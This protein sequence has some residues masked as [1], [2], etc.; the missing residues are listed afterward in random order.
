MTHPDHVSFEDLCAHVQDLRTVLTGLAYAL[1]RQANLN[2]EQLQADL[3]EI[4][5]PTMQEP[6]VVADELATLLASSILRGKANRPAGA[7][8]DAGS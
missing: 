8:P 6:N 2:A 4:C 3:L 1:G 7:R 5:L